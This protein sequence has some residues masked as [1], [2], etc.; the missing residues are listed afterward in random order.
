MSFSTPSKRFHQDF[1]PSSGFTLVEILVAVAIIG[2]LIT[3]V[4]VSLGSVGKRSAS[5]QSQSNLRQLG[6]AMHLF[7]TE[8]NGHFPPA[9]SQTRNEDGGWQNLGAWDGFL[10]PFLGVDA[11]PRH[12]GAGLTAAQLAG[13]SA[14][15]SHPGDTSVIT[16]TFSDGELRPRRTY[17]MPH[18]EGMVGIATW[19]GTG[20]FPSHPLSAIVDPSRTFLLVEKPG[21]ENNTINRT[22]LSGLNSASE[23]TTHQKDLNPGGRFNYLFCDGHVA[24]MRVEDT[25]GTGTMGNPRGF[26]TIDPTD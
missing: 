8:N 20:W 23:Q 12:P 25:I 26:W 19:E 2:V 7:A 17:A 15:L 1:A 21:F 11:N 6:A 10:L 5:V 9:A 22:G 16:N 18:R 24:S 14:L 3:I 13:V 4:F